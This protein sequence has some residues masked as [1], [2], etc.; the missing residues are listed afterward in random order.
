[1]A[2][3]AGSAGETVVHLLPGGLFVYVRIASFTNS[4]WK[5]CWRDVVATL[6]G[7]EAHTISASKVADLNISL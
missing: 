7:I 4:S 2:V 5:C 6:I 3:A 1:M